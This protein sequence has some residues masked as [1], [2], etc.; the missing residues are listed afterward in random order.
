MKMG[1]I[2]DGSQT[3]DENAEQNL[4]QQNIIAVNEI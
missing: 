2:M 4:I 3:K 1:T